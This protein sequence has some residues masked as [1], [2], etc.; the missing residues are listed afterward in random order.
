MIRHY[1]WKPDTCECVINQVHDDVLNLW[2]AEETFTNKQGKV[3]ETVRCS[4]HASINDVEELYGVLYKNPDGENKVKNLMEKHFLEDSNAGVSEEVDDPSDSSK[5]IRRFKQ[6]IKY[7]W[8]FEGTGKNRKLRCGIEGATML[9][10]KKDAIQNH[11][12]QAFGAGR[13][14]ML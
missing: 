14:E 5:K 10:A 6:G 4:A 8:R 2:S 3:F 7:T 1:R 9:K 12:D 11:A 13:V